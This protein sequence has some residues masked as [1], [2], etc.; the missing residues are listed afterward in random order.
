M[1]KK[2]VK[3]IKAK[4]YITIKEV[5][6]GYLVTTRE[7]GQKD[8]DYDNHI[9]HVFDKAEIENLISFIEGQIV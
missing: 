9:E 1:T 6:N 3:K 8:W 7:P 4:A 5:T 2:T